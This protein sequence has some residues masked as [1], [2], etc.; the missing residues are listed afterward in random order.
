[1][2]GNLGPNS[3]KD[4]AKA[5]ILVVDDNKVNQKV[6]TALLDR[7]ALASEIANDGQEAVD[8]AGRNKYSVILMDCHMPV[9]DGFE[10]TKA[11]RKLESAA[12]TYTPIIAV[13][14]MAM[15]G[16]R[17]RCI[18]SGMDDYMSKP[19]D[20]DLL[21]IKLNHWLREDVV[22]SSLKMARKYFRM[23][24]TSDATCMAD[25]L[26]FYGEAKIDEIIR[27][28]LFETEDLLRRIE[29]FVKEKRSDAVAGLAHELKASSASIGAKSMARLGLYMEQSA[30][31]Q[32]WAE[33]EVSLQ[34][35][36]RQFEHFKEFLLSATWPSISEIKP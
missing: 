20:K 5:P 15:A 7:L 25:L 9:M 10:A 11:I 29:V 22:Y 12:G 24:N 28:Y 32:D 31:Q 6:M 34:S 19:V 2:T 16:D 35:L 18:A 30:G 33:A 21:K 8:M 14:A 4:G 1:M 23:D 13:T 17:E 36:K 3:L 27:V 26:E